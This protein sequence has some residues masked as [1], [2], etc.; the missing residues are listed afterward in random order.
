MA[1]KSIKCGNGKNL[2]NNKVSKHKFK[3]G[4]DKKNY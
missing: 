2:Y 1:I 4:N 3:C